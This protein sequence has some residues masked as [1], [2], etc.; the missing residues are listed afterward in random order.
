MQADPQLGH[1]FAAI[2]RDLEELT[3]PIP[4]NHILNIDHGGAD[5]LKAVDP[6]GRLL[7][8][9]RRLLEERNKL[10]SQ[11]KTLPRLDTF[12]KSPSFDTWVLRNDAEII[13]FGKIQWIDEPL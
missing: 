13:V 2:S 10:I 7:L 9:Q 12:L 4:P 8:K 3:K 5:D 6:F 1:K 11:I